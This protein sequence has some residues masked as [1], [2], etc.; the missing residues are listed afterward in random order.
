MTFELSFDKRHGYRSL[1]SGITIETKLRS[2]ENEII[3]DAKID[4]GSQICLFGRDVG[5]A[6]GLNIESGWRMPVSTLTGSLVTFGHAVTLETLG[7]VFESFVYFA[8]SYDVRRN[9]LGREG[10]LQLVRLAVVDYDA[11]LYLSPYQEPSV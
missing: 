8:D 4:T 10:W 2:G 1:K 6:L 3:T 5:E 9:I 11:E 7:L